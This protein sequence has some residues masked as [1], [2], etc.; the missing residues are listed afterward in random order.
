[1]KKF[2]IASSFLIGIILTSCG[3][4]SDNA[5]I[6]RLKAELDSLK[7]QQLNSQSNVTES[8]VS[9]EP[10][11]TES[12]ESSSNELASTNS[13]IDNASTS[14]N[15]TSSSS[16]SSSKSACVG[17]YKFTDEINT[18]W[19]LKLNADETATISSNDGKSEA[20]GSWNYYSHSD[21]T[22]ISFSDQVPLIWF[23]AGEER[24][25]QLAIK[26]GYIYKGISGADAK[27]PRLRLSISK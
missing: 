4:G 26:E 13:S 21:L 8:S 15:F 16:S 10:S 24:G 1:M 18:T 23:P 9:D 19:T 27:N 2:L 3:G 12:N 25:S 7:S 6:A 20:Y 22:V 11:L 14:S 5:E 17:T